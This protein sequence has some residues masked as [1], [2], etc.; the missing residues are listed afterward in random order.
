[1]DM[2]SGL[3]IERYS[4]EKNGRLEWH[5]KELQVAFPT[6][7]YTPVTITDDV[8]IQ[9]IKKAGS[10][11]DI[12]LQAD[13]CYLPSAVQENRSSRPFFPKIFILAEEK[14][15]MVLDFEMFENDRDDADVAL[16]QLIK[17]C[18]D[19]GTPKEI[20]IKSERMAAIMGDFC[21]KTHIKLK[22]VQSLQ[23]IDRV[24]EGITSQMRR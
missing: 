23:T 17:M 3:T 24:I 2:E 21:K 8:L 5:N 18:L 4:E 13:I 9:K 10:M 22:T 6:L 15:G 19:K 14:S 1:M 7:S 20:Q 11:G 12:T 16:N